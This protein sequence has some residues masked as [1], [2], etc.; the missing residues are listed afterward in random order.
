M[1]KAGVIVVKLPSRTQKANELTESSKMEKMVG[2]VAA[3]SSIKVHFLKISSCKDLVRS[4]RFKGNK[5][6]SM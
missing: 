3:M 6:D 1:I 2:L 4:V 5:I